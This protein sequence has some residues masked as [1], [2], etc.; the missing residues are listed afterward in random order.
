MNI[1]VRLD[2]D[3][4]N[5]LVSGIDQRLCL[6]SR[7]CQGVTHLQT[8]GSIILEISNFLTFGIQFSRCIKCNI[9]QTVIQQLVDILPVNSFSLA[10]TIRT[11]FATKVHTFVEFDTQP[12]KRFNNISLRSRNKPLRVGIFN[13]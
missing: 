4:D 8:G 2:L 12:G 5:I 13:T 10:L 11:V 7:K 6:F 1:F 9:S 3:T